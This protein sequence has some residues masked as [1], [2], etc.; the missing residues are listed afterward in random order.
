MKFQRFNL[1]L[2]LIPLAFAC[3]RNED[4]LCN[5]E[6]DFKI[7]DYAGFECYTNIADAK[8]CARI[9]NKPIF[10]LFTGYACVGDTHYEEVL[11]LEKECRR[12]LSENFIPVVLH[13]DD[14]ITLPK[15]Y[16]KEVE[17][18]DGSR[19]YLKTTGMFNQYYQFSKFQSNTQPFMVVL[20]AD[21]NILLDPIGY[22]SLHEDYYLYLLKGVDT[23][24]K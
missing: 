16:K 13:V 18:Y 9:Q 2:L 19:R 12:L 8:D 22:Q 7:L 1:L 20:D 24:K 17:W 10:L 5:L 14:K 4:S 3:N 21:E 11:F 6:S 15:K 23:F